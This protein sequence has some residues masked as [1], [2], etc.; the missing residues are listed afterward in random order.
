MGFRLD[1]EASPDPVCEACKAGKMHA[2]PFPASTSRASK[3]FHLVHSDV[4]GP[5]KVPFLQRVAIVAV[6]CS[7]KHLR[8]KLMVLSEVAAWGWKLGLVCYVSMSC[9]A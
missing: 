4:H 8:S 5:V 1:S 2:D 3:L 9:I 6:T 7:R